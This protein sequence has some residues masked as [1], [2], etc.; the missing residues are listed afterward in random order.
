MLKISLRLLPYVLVLMTYLPFLNQAYHIDDRIYLQ[1]AENIQVK[2]FYPYDFEALFEGF[3]APDAASHSHLPLTSYYL[4]LIKTLN[5][6]MDEWLTHLAFLIFPLMA[7]YGFK[8]IAQR[9][10]A[11]PQAATLLFAS[12]TAFM[13]LSHTLMPDVPF[14]AFWMVSLRHFFEIVSGNRTRSRDWLIC[15]GALLGA[16]FLSLLSFGLVMLFLVY[17]FLENRYSGRTQISWTGLLILAGFP[18]LLWTLWYLRGYLHYDRFV[19]VNT[20]THMEHRAFLSLELIAKKVLS[21]VM[22]TGA[23]FF[24]PLKQIIP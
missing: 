11:F 9:F 4:A 16:S 21:F 7:V 13:V 19:L 14:M 24:F 8:G 18:I 20:F 15:G 6:Q 5:P 23:T 3:V 2:P 1:I 10:V 17:P 22:N 12:S